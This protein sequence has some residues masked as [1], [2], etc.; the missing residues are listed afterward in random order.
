MYWPRRRKLKEAKVCLWL[1]LVRCMRIRRLRSGGRRTE[2]PWE[3]KMAF[4]DRKGGENILIDTI[5]STSP[6][7]D[8]LK[9]ACLLGLITLTRSKK[10]FY[11]FHSISD[12]EQ[13]SHLV[14]PT[15]FTSL[16]WES[17]TLPIILAWP[18]TKWELRK[19]PSKSEV[20]CW[21]TSKR[22][23]LQAMIALK[24]NRATTIYVF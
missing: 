20:I 18:S 7:Y 22:L 19:H 14:V 10:F 9:T 4:W 24:V 11:W 16:Q 21:Y 2:S 23:V 5:T 12:I 13:R 6:R 3:E 17:R 1:S 8:W 15:V